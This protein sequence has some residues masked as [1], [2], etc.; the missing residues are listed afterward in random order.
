MLVD[1]DPVR[2]RSQRRTS[3]A[4]ARL[5]RRVAE[6][7]RADGGSS[8]LLRD[9]ARGS[10]SGQAR[11]SVAVQ[12][13]LTTSRDMPNSCQSSAADLA[14]M[15]VSPRSQPNLSHEAQS[16]PTGPVSPRD[17]AVVRRASSNQLSIPTPPPATAPSN[18]PETLLGR[19]LLYC[20]LPQDITRLSRAARPPGPA[21]IT[22][23][24]PV[25]SGSVAWLRGAR[26]GFGYQCG[27][28][29]QFRCLVL[30]PMRRRVQ[31]FENDLASGHVAPEM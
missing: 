7:R 11:K 30:Y 1:R 20:V 19:R 2:G 27:L 5:R 22:A 28:I 14:F 15:T 16:L 26:G 9:E 4:R 12:P 6:V 3:L 23:T 25:I 24:L 31:H 29:R 18:P 21:P 8:P 17:K 13:R 10:A